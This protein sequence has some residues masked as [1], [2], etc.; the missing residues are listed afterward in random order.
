M[1][2]GHSVH[3]NHELNKSLSQKLALKWFL[4]TNID[5]SDYYL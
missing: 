4:D 5:L 2:G 1:I 3:P